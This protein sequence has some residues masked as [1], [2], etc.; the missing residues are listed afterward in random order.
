[1][2]KYSQEEARSSKGGR[3]TTIQRSPFYLH[4]RDKDTEPPGYNQFALSHTE[5]EWQSRDLNPD[6]SDFQI[7]IAFHDPLLK[8]IKDE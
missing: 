6:L 3:L 7:Y 1:M 4:P 2:K 8:V 5:R